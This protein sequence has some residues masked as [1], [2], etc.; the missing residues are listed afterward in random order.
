MWLGIVNNR[1]ITEQGPKAQIIVKGQMIPRHNGQRWED[2]EQRNSM[3]GVRTKRK[4]TESLLQSFIY[5]FACLSQ[6]FKVLEFNKI[7]G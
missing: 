2:F 3:E 1:E 5:V 7:M 4:N 6:H